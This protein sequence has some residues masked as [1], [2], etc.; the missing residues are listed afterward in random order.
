[1]TASTT[2]LS[3]AHPEVQAAA[4]IFTDFGGRRTFGG[5]IETV[6]VYEDNVL[7]KAMLETPGD[8]RVLVVDGGG[9][10][11][12]ALVGDVLAGIGAGNGWAG[13]VIY[14]CVR[15]TEA[16]GDLDIGVKALAA[17]PIRSEKRGVGQVSLPVSFAGVTFRP[18]WWLYADADGIIVSRTELA[19]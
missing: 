16:L 11:R 13:I 10:R 2:D 17:F 7:V 18:G 1:M 14:G 4:P 3:D 12:R 8:G 9:S 19:G 5:P 6:R 15:D